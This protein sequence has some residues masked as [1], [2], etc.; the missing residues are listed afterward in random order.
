MRINEMTAEVH[1]VAKEK[2]WWEKPKSPLEVYA[3]I[4]SEV[5][6]AVEEARKGTEPIYFTNSEGKTIVNDVNHLREKHGLP[7]EPYKPE[8]ELIEL[9]DCVIRVMDYCGYKGWDLEEAIRLKVE[10]NKTRS[11]RHGGKL[12]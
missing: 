8:G 4:H 2:G 7:G 11:H 3:L 12:Y 5:S 10:Y 9:A 6:E 1:G